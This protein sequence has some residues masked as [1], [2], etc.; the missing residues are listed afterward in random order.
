MNRRCFTL[1]LSRRTIELGRRTLVM[2]VVNVTPDS[3]SDG[4]EY[5]DH[6]RAVERALEI[7]AEGADIIDIGG[8]SARPGAKPITF[9]EELRR[10]MP[11]IERVV[12]RVRIPLS[13]DTTKF[14]VAR[15]ALGAGIEII[16]DVSGLRWDE[17]LADLA[18]D[19]GAA[20]VVMN[21]RGMPETMQ[22][23][24]PS[25]DIF[26]EIE[27]YLHWAIEWAVAHGVKREQ[28]LLDPGIGF[29]KTVE[30]NLV[31]INHLDRFAHFDLPLII[32]TSRKMFI[33]KILNKPPQERLMGT[34]ASVVAA[35][36]RGAHIVR[37]H[38]VREMVEVVKV[39][40]AISNATE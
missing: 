24:P 8:E 12:G 26:A 31:L 33:G 22:T 23:I 28:L 10:V 21:M 37:V 4:G 2:G 18:A 30:Q 15:V 19:Y 27:E 29:G 3:F 40:D 5:F 13:I 36:F 1:K 17:R 38:D 14:D 32:G 6:D 11:V 20:L 35:I 34:A 25:P 39:A 16:N 7:E 9:E